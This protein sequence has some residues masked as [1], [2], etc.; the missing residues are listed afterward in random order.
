MNLKQRDLTVGT[1]SYGT[2]PA[3]SASDAAAS[4]RLLTQL[5]GS[6]RTKLALLTGGGGGGWQTTAHAF[7]HLVHVNKGMLVIMHVNVHQVV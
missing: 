5:T 1:S 4:A 3:T 7:Q 6:S 2:P